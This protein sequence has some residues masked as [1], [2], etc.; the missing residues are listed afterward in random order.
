MKKSLV[1]IGLAVLLLVPFASAGFFDFMTGKTT[2]ADTNVTAQIIS[3]QNTTI[4]YVAFNPTL[5]PVE[6]TSVTEIVNFTASDLDGSNDII[7]TSGVVRI[8]NICNGGAS[9]TS[10]SCEN[11]TPSGLAVIDVNFTCSVNLTYY[12]CVS[13]DWVVNVSI[14][15][16]HATINTAYND[17]TRLNVTF[18]RSVDISPLSVAF[19][20]LEALSSNQLSV[21]NNSITNYGNQIPNINLTSI[22]LH[23][24]SSSA[25]IFPSNNFTALAVNSSNSDDICLNGIPLANATGKIVATTAGSVGNRPLL[26][27]DGGYSGATT[28][29]KYC[30]PLVPQLF[31]QNYTTALAGPWTITATGWAN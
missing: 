16:T 23:G 1:I 10:Y 28:Q 17:T 21:I 26:N 2:S 4:P 18:V 20:P 27:K 3:T 22:D 13:T 6:N 11:I 8:T 15:Y 19:N 31:A 7:L 5:Q 12:D 9:R 14:N 29:L 24:Q 30:I 25:I